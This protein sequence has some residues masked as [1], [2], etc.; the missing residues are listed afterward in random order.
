M[1]ALGVVLFVLGCF[2][3]AKWPPSQDKVR[4]LS[5]R[6]LSPISWLIGIVLMAASLLKLLWWALP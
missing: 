4:E 2:G 3:Y 6:D 5:W 1:M